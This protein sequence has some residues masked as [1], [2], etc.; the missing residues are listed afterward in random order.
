MKTRE[1]RYPIGGSLPPLSV[2]LG[3]EVRA[4]A[5]R[6]GG[7]WALTAGECAQ[8][9]ERMFGRH[10]LHGDDL[11]LVFDEVFRA[12]DERKEQSR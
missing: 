1:F 3:G 5:K 9:A 6:R 12:T 11:Q 2:T 10:P 7:R 4:E 8:R